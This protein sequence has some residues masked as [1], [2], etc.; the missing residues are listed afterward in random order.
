MLYRKNVNNKERIIR[1]VAGGLMI[2]C[3]LVALKASLLGILLACVGVVAILTGMF[4][5]CP[6]CSMAGRKAIGE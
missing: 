1:L 5:Y 4:R 6:A 2:L 3:G